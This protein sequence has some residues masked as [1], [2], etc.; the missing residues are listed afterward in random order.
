MNKKPMDYSI[1]DCWKCEH[2]ETC[3]HKD[4]FR[5]L[6]REVGGLGLCKNLSK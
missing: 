5:R 2:Q 6:P 1:C 3:I 4:A